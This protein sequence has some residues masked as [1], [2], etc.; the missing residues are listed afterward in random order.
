MARPKK[1]NGTGKT[2]GKRGGGRRSRAESMTGAKEAKV[3]MRTGE[4]ELPEVEI[5]SN[6][7]AYHMKSIKAATEKKDTANNLLRSC[8]KAAKQVHPKLPDAIKRAI[9]IERSD[10]GIADLRSELQVLGV[11]LRETGASLQITL[12]DTLLGDVKDQAFAKGVKDAENEHMSRS[13][14]PEGSDLDERYKAGWESVMAARV[15]GGALP[16]NGAEELREEAA[17]H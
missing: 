10:D 8:I 17:V 7:F 11:A 9:Q 4:L 5:A 16:S 1:Q 6:D 13:P 14:Y 3:E 2:K 15:T 12:H